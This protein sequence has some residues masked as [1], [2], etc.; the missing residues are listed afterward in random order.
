[1]K[2]RGKTKMGWV[3]YI[4]VF[5]LIVALGARLYVKE[6]RNNNKGKMLNGLIA[7]AVLIAATLGA[8]WV[9]HEFGFSLGGYSSSGDEY[10]NRPGIGPYEW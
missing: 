10:P 5:A 6:E 2:I 7:I 4:I 1:M 9:S 8:M 3:I